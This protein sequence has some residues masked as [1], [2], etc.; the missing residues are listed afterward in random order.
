MA[1]NAGDNLRLLALMETEHIRVKKVDRHGSFGLACTGAF[2]RLTLGAIGFD[3]R[4][5]CVE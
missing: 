4:Q 1:V 3:R 2:Q 5:P